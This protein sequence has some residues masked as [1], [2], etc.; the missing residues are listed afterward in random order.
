MTVAN[1]WGALLG[2]TALT[3][4]AGCEKSPTRE[5]TET[6]RTKQTSE[7]KPT[8][9]T[10][11]PGTKPGAAAAGGTTTA[12]MKPP[13][14][15]KFDATV[16]I[17]AKPGSKQFQGVWLVRADG[18]RLLIDYR[19]TGLWRPFEKQK[20]T[21]T[22]RT[23]YPRGQAIKAKHF[24]VE[25]LQMVDKQS[26]ASII[27]IGP[28]KT[29]NG[30]FSTHTVRAGAKGGGQQRTVFTSKSATTYQVMNP[31][32][33]LP[34]AAVVTAR[35]IERSPFISHVGGPALWILSA[36]KAP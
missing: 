31:A 4:L 2:L 36:S 12:P 23:Y 11:E 35:E 25:T 27:R 24:R 21:A 30:A 9:T 16:A 32:A 28:V 6:P 7:T 10:T 13:A 5:G 22:G 26:T 33:A 18:S 17:D 20:V 3:A 34:G 14:T 1:R 19:A 29:L 15:M 8:A